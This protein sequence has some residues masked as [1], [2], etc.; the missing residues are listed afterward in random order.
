MKLCCIILR[1]LL[2][3]LDYDHDLFHSTIEK[4]VCQSIAK[5]I[6]TLELVIFLENDFLEMFEDEYFS[7]QVFFI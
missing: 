2:L 4:S 1:R 7:L 5:L 6:S 3:A